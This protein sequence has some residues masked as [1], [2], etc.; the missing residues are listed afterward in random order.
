LLKFTA[1]EIVIVTVARH[2]F[3]DVVVARCVVKEEEKSKDGSRCFLLLESFDFERKKEKSKN[4]F[5]CLLSLFFFFQLC[6]HR[7][8]RRK[9]KRQFLLISSSIELRRRL[10]CRRHL[11]ILS[12]DSS[13]NHLD[14]FS[15][16]FLEE[17]RFCS[18]R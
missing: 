16:Q 4:N 17:L 13:R 8:R 5:R 6:C 14:R 9:I 11:S 15:H 3:Y 2:A 18:M 10:R 7:L 1:D 12:L